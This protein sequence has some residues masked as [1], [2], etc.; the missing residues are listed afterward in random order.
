MD[1]V[2][3]VILPEN[4]RWLNDPD[5]Q[6][7]CNAIGA[8]G[9]RIFF[10]GGCV[11]DA[12]LGVGGSDVD[13][14]TDA[15]PDEVIALATTAGLK[16]VP[17]GIEHGTVTVVAG[18]KGF[19][20]TTFRRDVETDGRRAVVTFS[21]DISDDAVRRDFTMNAL[22]ATP[23]G[24]VIDPLG[25]G[26][27]DC[28]ARH[29]R[30]IQ[31]AETRIREDYLRILRYFRFHAWYADAQAGFDADALDAIASNTDGLE[32][33][34]AER[35]GAE[36]LRLLAAPDPS[37]AVA[38][39]RQ[40]GVLSKVLPG[41]DDQFL[42]PVVYLESSVES[43]PDALLRLASLGGENVAE[44]LRLSRAARKQLETLHDQA[45]NGGGLAE[46]AYRHGFDMAQQVAVLR[47]AYSG[48]PVLV[49]DL[50]AIDTG[51]RAVCPVSASDLIP[52]FEGKALGDRLA[53]LETRWIASNFRLTREELMTGP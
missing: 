4:T 7:V 25:H 11:R 33:L 5:A 39:M 17:T 47:A 19:E 12:L 23:N 20:V 18:G 35:T 1:R 50:D 42:A 34:S 40:T 29:V 2:D 30:F 53:A 26:V 16:A 15:K 43:T 41:S 48:Q 6:A 46:V 14:S 21:K 51:A 27:E 31:D 38:T 49:T 3:E 9:A 13:L 52:D 8:Q 28:L 44:S 37:P 36:L 32:T 24:Q 45:S 10:V 22:Y